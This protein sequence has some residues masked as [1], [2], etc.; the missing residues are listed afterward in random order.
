VNKVKRKLMAALVTAFLAMLIAGG[1]ALAA[2]EPQPG[3]CSPDVPTWCKGT[4]DS[5]TLTGTSGQDRLEALAGDDV[6]YGLG[7]TDS[8]YG[9]DGNDTIYGDR[10]PNTYSGDPGVA[11]WDALYGGNGEDTLYGEAGVDVLYAGKD[12]NKDTL[13][14]G[15]GFDVYVVRAGAYKRGNDKVVED[16]GNLGAGV[17]LKDSDSLKPLDLLARVDAGEGHLYFYPE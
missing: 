10:A 16:A 14:G 4:N 12:A 13:N 15:D 9:Q 11:N 5:E 6:I 1:V 2:T 8:L 3:T 7:D 17:Q